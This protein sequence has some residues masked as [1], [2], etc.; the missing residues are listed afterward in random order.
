MK[1][2]FLGLV[3]TAAL[4]FAGEAAMKCGAGK[5]GA[6]MKEKPQMKCGAGKCGAS[7]KDKNTTKA[8]KCGAS[9]KEK[10]TMKCGAGKCGGGK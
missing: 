1:K 8:T 2:L 9:M 5:C 7:M 10:K 6:S 4:V 3:A